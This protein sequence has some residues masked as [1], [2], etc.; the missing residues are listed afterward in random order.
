[1]EYEREVLKN[2]TAVF[3]SKNHRFGTDAMLLSGFCRPKRQEAAA[4]LCSGC[5]ILALRWHDL[6]HRGRCEAVELCGEGSRLLAA[7][8]AQNGIGHIRPVTADLRQFG[9][10]AP[11]CF[12]FVGCNPPYFNAGRKSPD[13]VRAAARHEGSCTLRDAAECA[14]R[15]LRYGGRFAL[16]GKPQRLAETL[17]LLHELGL[18][19]KRLALVKKTP[20][21]LPALFLCEAKKGGRP[22]LQF[23]PDLL[24]GEG[25][26]GY[27]DTVVLAQDRDFP[28]GI[29]DG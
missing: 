10:D 22:G 23:M 13:P 4:D 28:G 17:C 5:G 24:T 14:A 3:I 6:G 25:A 9:L 27:D 2:G 8:C 21:S 15:L 26:G 20:R 1:M 18:E 16:C 7:A 29:L 11:Q 19:P 12:D